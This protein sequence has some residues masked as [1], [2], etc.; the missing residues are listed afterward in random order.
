MRENVYECL[1]L[2]DSNRYA[3]NPAGVSGKLPEA[4]EAAGGEVLANRL[5]GEQKLAYPIE[6]HKKGVYWLTYFRMPTD[7]LTGFN[8][9][10]QL[11]E[12]ILRQMVIKVEPR[13]V[14]VLVSHA[15][16]AAA[17]TPADDEKPEDEEKAADD[18][19]SSEESEEAA[20]PVAA[21]EDDA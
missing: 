3:R 13:L 18:G 6:G 5:W 19:D 14:D 10:C 11:N 2:L 20:E 12:D 9:A 8:R 7:Q 21:G 16:G 17:E 1:F 4:I 15:L